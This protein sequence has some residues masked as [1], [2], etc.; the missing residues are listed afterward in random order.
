M[1]DP[2]QRLESSRRLLEQRLDDLRRSLER[3]VGWVPKSGGWTL[4]LVGFAVGMTLAGAVARW[5][6]KS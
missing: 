1:Q 5:R 4:P 6:R 3:E 2:E